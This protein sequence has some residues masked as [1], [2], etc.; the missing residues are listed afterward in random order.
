HRLRV[1]DPNLHVAQPLTGELGAGDLR[2]PLGHLERGDVLGADDPGEVRRDGAGPA[3]HVQQPL[4]GAQMRQQVGGGV[5]GGAG[6]VAVQHG[7]A[8]AVGV[9]GGRAGGGVCGIRH[10]PTLC[11]ARGAGQG[12]PSDGRR[13]REAGPPPHSGGAPPA[14]RWAMSSPMCSDQ[15]GSA[16]LTVSAAPLRRRTWSRPESSRR[17]SSAPATSVAGTSPRTFQR[18]TMLYTVYTI[19]RSVTISSG[20]ESPLRAQRRTSYTPSPGSR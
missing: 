4:P 20:Q 5:P 3:A 1:A 18:V 14:A 2:G 10:G 7:G 9:G 8:V 12:R 13:Q 11:G 17:S 6:T 16:T 19:R 15:A